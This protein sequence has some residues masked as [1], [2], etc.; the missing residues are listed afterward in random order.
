MEG[1]PWSEWSRGR[2]VSPR[3]LANVLKGFGIAPGTIC[4]NHK[5]TAKG[6]KRTS[7]EPIWM[8][9]GIPNP[10]GSRKLSVTPSQPRL[11]A[12]FGDCASVTSPD[13]VTDR[14]R[15]NPTVRAGCDVVMDG[16]PTATYE[17]ADNRDPNARHN[18]VADADERAAILQF[19]GE[20]PKADAEQMAER[21]CGLEPG[22]LVNVAT[23]P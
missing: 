2:P 10:E 5:L 23:Q 8:R 18:I 6:Y 7:F 21:Q 11:S 19:E 20:M 13:S 17:N 3:G 14:N 22:T 15:P 16:N 4:L 12:V 9:Y 1:R